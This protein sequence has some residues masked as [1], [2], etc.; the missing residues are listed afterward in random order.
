MIGQA[1]R[2]KPDHA[3]G[4]SDRRLL[5]DRAIAGN[6]APIKIVGG[7]RQIMLIIARINK[8]E[9]PPFQ[10]EKELSN[11]DLRLSHRYLD[12]RR[13]RMAKNLRL[14]HAVRGS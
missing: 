5:R 8:S 1:R 3:S 12:L 4:L 9:V 10:L 11:E 2:G 13:P 6:V 14:R 7:S